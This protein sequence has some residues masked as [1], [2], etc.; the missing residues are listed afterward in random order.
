MRN[1]PR[2]RRRWL[3]GREEHERSRPT[4]TV[5]PEDA[6]C[7]TR[8]SHFQRQ[9]RNAVLQEFA[10]R[11]SNSLPGGANS[12]AASEEIGPALYPRSR[13]YKRARFFRSE[14]LEGDVRH[15]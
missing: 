11:G 8:S 7:G 12:L 13:R 5:S 6:R 1:V 3:W 4:I 15:E 10:E 14:P 2:S 9:G